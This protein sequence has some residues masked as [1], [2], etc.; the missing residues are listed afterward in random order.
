MAKKHHYD[1]QFNWSLFRVLLVEIERLEEFFIS[2]KISFLKFQGREVTVDDV[3]RVYEVFLDEARSSDN[4]R[5]Y[6]QYFMF[7]DLTSMYFI[8]FILILYLFFSWSTKNRIINNGKL[9][10]K[11]PFFL[12]VIVIRINKFSLRSLMSYSRRTWKE[13]IIFSEIISSKIP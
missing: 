2:M 3:K 12:F 7:N 6:E 1:I 4:L 10:L 11:F 5:E 13:F 9:I 8:I